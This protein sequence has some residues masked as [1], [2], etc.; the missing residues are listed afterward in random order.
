MWCAEASLAVWSLTYEMCD[1]VF[2]HVDFELVIP[3]LFFVWSHQ[4]L[5]IFQLLKKVEW[6]KNLL[7]LTGLDTSF[8]LGRLW[9]HSWCELLNKK[10]IKLSKKVTSKML[11]TRHQLAKQIMIVGYTVGRGSHF[12]NNV[13]FLHITW[14]W[15][16]LQ[17][18]YC[19]DC[20]HNV[21]TYKPE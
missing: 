18:W 6:Y 11:P 21:N 15:K 17:C 1:L 20:L 14:E 10:W 16:E 12:V 19:H 5:A 8:Y 7:F 13:C 4:F 2:Y 3:G 9:Y